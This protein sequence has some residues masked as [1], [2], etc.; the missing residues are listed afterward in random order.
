MH[1]DERRK[2]AGFSTVL[3][4]IRI[5]SCCCTF[6]T[7]YFKEAMGLI[8]LDFVLLFLLFIHAFAFM[9]LADAFVQCIALMHS[10]HL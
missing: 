10:N 3:I 6:T 2:Y 5:N 8:R 4:S 1:I 9:H 7:H